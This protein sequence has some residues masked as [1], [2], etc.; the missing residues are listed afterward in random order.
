MEKS[1]LY[2]KWTLFAVVLGVIGVFVLPILVTMAINA[3]ILIILGLLGLSVWFLLPAICEWL[4]QASMYLWSKAITGDP[5]SRLRR[6][7][8]KNGEDIQEME[9]D[10]AGMTS[11]IEQTKGIIQQNKSKVDPEVLEA[12]NADLESLIQARNETMLVR[13]SEIKEYKRFETII[14][15]AEADV[16]VSKSLAKTAGLFDFAKKN[17]SR[18]MGSK[19]ALAEVQK[20]MSDSR[21]RMQAVLSRAKVSPAAPVQTLSAP[22]TAN[23]VDVDVK[24]YSTVGRSN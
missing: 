18:S 19:V 20:R 21:G 1:T 15:K 24:A 7:L 17:G 11:G 10:I 2:L 3:T 5:I 9:K 14:S 6:D 4:A 22:T 12:W 16:E 13:D 8:K 23:V